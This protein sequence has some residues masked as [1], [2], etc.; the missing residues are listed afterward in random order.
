VDRHCD[1][2]GDDP[3]EA[4]VSVGEVVDVAYVLTCD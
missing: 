4:D 1:I 3:V 2:E